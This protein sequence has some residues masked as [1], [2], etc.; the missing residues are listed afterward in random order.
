MTSARPLGRGPSIYPRG[1]VFTAM[2]FFSVPGDHVSLVCRSA[3]RYSG[4]SR[5]CR[6]MCAWFLARTPAISGLR[7]RSR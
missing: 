3:C 6:R 4:R 5:S 2:V 1:L 7:M